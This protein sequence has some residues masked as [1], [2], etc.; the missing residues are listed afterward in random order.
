MGRAARGE[1][2]AAAD[3]LREILREAAERGDHPHHRDARREHIFSRPDVGQA[4]KRN[5]D[6][7]IADDR[8]GAAKEAELTSVS[9]KS[10]LICSASM[11]NTV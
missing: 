3:E 8:G 7:E 6:E 2:H 5:A 11:P 4:G 1:E 10:S 9:P